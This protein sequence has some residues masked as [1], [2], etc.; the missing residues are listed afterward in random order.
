[1]FYT[2]S[3]NNSGGSFDFQ[4]GRISKYVIIEAPNAVTA[5]AK[6]RELG[7]YFDGVRNGPDC[8]CCGDRWSE[9]WRDDDGE[10]FPCVYGESV[11]DLDQPSMGIKWIDGPEGYVHYE[12]G[13]VVPFW[14]LNWMGVK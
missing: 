9:Q 4:E 1:M 5:N 10:D 8:S 11:L 2:F 6:A 7:I 14:E 3:Q 13:N 12:D